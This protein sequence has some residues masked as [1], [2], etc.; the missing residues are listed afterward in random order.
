MGERLDE[1]KARFLEAFEREMTVRL[2]CEATGVRR[3]AF[4]R[5]RRDD[6]DFA[7]S[8][9]RAEANVTDRAQELG[10]KHAGM[11]PWTDDDKAAGLHRTSDRRMV[12]V[13]LRRDNRYRDAGLQQHNT[14]MAL[15]INGISGE[16]IKKLLTPDDPKA[17]RLGDDVQIRD[18]AIDLKADEADIPAPDTFI[19]TENAP[20]PVMAKL[21]E[22]QME[23][24]HAAREARG[25]EVRE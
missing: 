24:R 9:L 18:R 2:A 8:F 21:L 5:W 13:L 10:F 12:E 3:A 15:T 11:K 14:V 16:D 22:H 17:Q 7:Q 6:R 20:P 23:R 1:E 19:S 25:V 4:D